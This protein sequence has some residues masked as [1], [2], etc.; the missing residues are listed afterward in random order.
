MGASGFVSKPF[1]VK[2]TAAAGAKDVGLELIDKDSSSLV[3][4]KKVR[5]RSDISS[6]S[7]QPSCVPGIWHGKDFHRRV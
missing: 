5:W 4:L 2:R 7:G 3:P 1:R 6:D